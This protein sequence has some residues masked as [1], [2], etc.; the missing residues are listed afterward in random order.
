MLSAQD[1]ELVTRVGPGTPMGALFREYWLP[2]LLSSELPERDG[3]PC[4]VRILGE[5]LVAFRTTSGQ[6]GLLGDKCPHRGAPLYYGRNEEEGLRCVYHGWKYDVTGRCVDMPSEPP[7]S[8]FK[9]K[10]RQR[11]YPCEERSGVIWT[12]MGPRREPPPFPHFE[13]ATLPSEHT[14]HVKFTEDCNWMQIIEG[15]L[16][17]IHSDFL[18]ARIDWGKF[19]TP[20]EGIRSLTHH[21]KLELVRTDCGFAK[22]ARRELDPAKYPDQ[23][24]WRIYQWMMPAFALLPAAGNSIAYRATIPIDDTHTIFWNGLYCPT[25]PLTAEERES[26]QSS[27]TA[28][29]FLPSTGDP[30][31]K[32]RTIG[33]HE[34]DYLLDMEAQRTTLFSGMPPAKMQDVAMTEGMGPVLDRTVE[35]LGTTDTAIIEMRN[36]VLAAVKAL[37]DHGTTPPAVDTPEAFAVRSAQAILPKSQSWVDATRD[38]LTVSDRPLAVAPRPYRDG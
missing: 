10:I 7:E 35:H 24:H 26:H 33:N 30:L 3:M 31:T 21:A 9:D 2:I 18:H 27:R 38:F 13:W 34:N 11:A 36:Q 22:G 16:D 5:D 17:T 6:V 1:N 28:G 25:R 32:W 19:A 14:D 23:Y 8:N 15:D 29:G 4:R 20:S 12:Y 37:R